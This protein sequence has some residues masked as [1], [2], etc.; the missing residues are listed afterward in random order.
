LI[1]AVMSVADAGPVVRCRRPLREV[2]ALWKSA[3]GDR[4]PAAC[5]VKEALWL[6]L[7]MCYA[8]FGDW[9]P[10]IRAVGDCH[11]EAQDEKAA[12]SFHRRVLAQAR[13]LP[14][15]HDGWTCGLAAAVELRML[16]CGFR[17]LAASPEAAW[18]DFV[19]AVLE[20]AKAAPADFRLEPVVNTDDIDAGP[21]L[22]CGAVPAAILR[23]ARPIAEAVASSPVAAGELAISVELDAAERDWA[24]RKRDSPERFLRMQACPFLRPHVGPPPGTGYYIALSL[25]TRAERG[26]ADCRSPW[27][28]IGRRLP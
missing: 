8:G 18:K 24:L 4:G 1:V 6:E 28:W 13:D 9:L 12:V 11:I 17:W 20:P 21:D 5:R 3:Q 10:D 25:A 26:T 19:G 7:R 16:D 15:T 23:N 14:C 22:T 2:R 27:S